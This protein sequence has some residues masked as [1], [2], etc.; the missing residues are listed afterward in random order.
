MRLISAAIKLTATCFLLLVASL[1]YSKPVT[2]D[3]EIDFRDGKVWG[4]YG[5]TSFSYDGITVSANPNALYRDNVDGYGILGGSEPDEIDHHELLTVWID[6]SYYEKTG[7]LLTGVLLTDLFNAPDG[8]PS[9]EAGWVTLYDA[10]NNILAQF[11]VNAIYDSSNGEYYLNFGGSYAPDRIVFTAYMDP[12]NGYTGS[13]FSVAGFTVAV[14]E[15]ETLAILGLG[16]LM[17]AFSGRRR[18]SLEPTA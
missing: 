18:R 14:N 13:E 1:A 11:F 17:L 10:D 15:P 5:G 4:G 6:K 8:G 2:V 7:H 9:G 16:L 3:L 12:E